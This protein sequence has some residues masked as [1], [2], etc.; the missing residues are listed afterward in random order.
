MM[1]GS[2]PEKAFTWLCSC[3][4]GCEEALQLRGDRAADLL[5][6]RQ[7][8]ALAGLDSTE[9]R[10]ME[11]AAIASRAS[12]NGATPVSSPRDVILIVPQWHD[13]T[14]E[15]SCSLPRN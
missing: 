3:V 7:G 11:R 1:H 2:V 13:F 9:H 6:G 4:V 15:A 12:E 5:M 10:C 8:P 14:L